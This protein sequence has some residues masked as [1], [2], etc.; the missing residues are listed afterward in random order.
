[1]KTTALNP[2]AL[3]LT[4]S[5]RTND[6]CLTPYHSTEF[7]LDVSDC[8]EILDMQLAILT[9]RLGVL[10]AII[11]AMG[12]ASCFPIL[13]TL[14]SALGMGVLAQFEGVFINTLLPLFAVIALIA[15]LFSW[16]S[17]KQYLR[18]ILAISGPVMVLA[19]LYLFWTDVWSTYM[20]YIA[21]V[22]MFCVA[23][24]DLIAPPRQVCQTIRK[25][26]GA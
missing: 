19:T 17:H 3:S 24:W 8:F 2:L 10:G 7:I 26:K 1:M 25:H 21:L 20:F 5:H 12:C 18:G 16:W 9:E 15:G 22:L 6:S 23:I 4:L 11:S 14:G 13:G